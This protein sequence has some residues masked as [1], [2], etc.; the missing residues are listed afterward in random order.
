[1]GPCVFVTPISEVKTNP[2]STWFIGSHLVPDDLGVNKQAK[3][4]SQDV[5]PLGLME[6]VGSWRV[7]LFFFASVFGGLSFHPKKR[8]AGIT[9]DLVV[10]KM[11]FSFQGA[12]FRLHVGFWGVD[13][14][15]EKREPQ[16]DM[17]FLGYLT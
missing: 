17:I 4:M 9:Q 7:S 2:S 13:L 15:N 3:R 11:F 14:L 5:E 10:V 8:T 6:S 16:M 12:F 1:M